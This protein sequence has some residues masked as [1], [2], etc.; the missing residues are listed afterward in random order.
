MLDE[1]EL[2]IYGRQFSRTGFVGAL[3]WYRNV[4]ENWKWDRQLKESSVGSRRVEVTCP[5][6]MLSAEGD[7]VL[8]PSMV[9]SL[10]MEDAV[11]RLRHETI[12]G[13]G[14]WV[15]QEK[16]DSVNKV[17]TS[18]LDN[19]LQHEEPKPKL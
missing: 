2:R 16:P 6:L 8:K 4:E 1:H 10:R 9:K 7:E 14:H 11:P 12:A 3:S 5:C 15:L 17:L 19:L 18:F 13:A